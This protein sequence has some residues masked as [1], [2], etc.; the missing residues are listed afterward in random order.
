MKYAQGSIASRNQAV[1]MIFVPK[2]V[3]RGIQALNH[4]EKCYGRFKLLGKYL[5]KRRFFFV[6]AYAAALAERKK[7]PNGNLSFR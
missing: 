2:H 1:S 5:K 4:I 3:V 7:P 6:V